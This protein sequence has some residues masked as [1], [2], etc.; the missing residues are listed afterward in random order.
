MSQPTDRTGVEQTDRTG[1]DQT[2]RDAQPSYRTTVRNARDGFGHLLGAEWTKLRSVRSSVWCL[3]ATVLLTVLITP[4]ISASSSTNANEA[5]NYTDQFTFVHQPMAGDGTV[6]ARVSSQLNSQEWARAGLMIKQNTTAGSPYAAIMVTPRHGVRLQANFNT[7]IPGPDL[8]AP[9]WLRLT[10]SGA[11][12]TGSESTD[13]TTWHPVGTVRVGAL[14]PTA[15][16][17]MFVAS[18]PVLRVTKTSG[19]S[20]TSLVLSLGAATFDRVT[21]QPNAPQQLPGWSEL[22]LNGGAGTKG[23]PPANVPSDGDGPFTAGDGP[24]TVH[25]AGDVAGYGIPSFPLGD[26]DIVVNSLSG[27]QLGLLAV[28]ALG[29][30]FAAG[31]YKTGMI[32]TT[33]AA[34]P[35]RRRV[36]GAKAIVVG[37]AVF[38]AGLVASLIAFYVAQ[39][40]LRR[41]GYQPPAYPHPT[42]ADATVLRAVIGTALFLAVLAVFSLSVGVILKR[43]ARAIALVVGLVLVPQ[44]VASLVPSLGVANWINRLT[45]TAGLA[46]Q[47]TRPRFDYAIAPWGGFAVLCGYA[48]VALVVAIWLV[49]RR[50]A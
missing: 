21:I 44:I 13:G 9:R 24:F 19:G 31:E 34:T 18:P 27:V 12:I 26:D 17:G 29:V 40:V 20:S 15:E 36:L 37:V 46:I 6:V 49:R 16:I 43:S 41:H 30:L 22:M 35:R 2:F 42:L 23:A 50:D 7:D 11:V 38:V 39:P 47:H 32:R 5:P 10:R 48:A 45:P 8:G 3:L 4:L 33:F 14:A 1:A 28:I 25:G